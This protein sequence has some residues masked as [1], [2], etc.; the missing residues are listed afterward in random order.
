MIKCHLIET[1]TEVRREM[2]GL[3]DG[4]KKRKEGKKN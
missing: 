1:E 4:G 3:T 2:E